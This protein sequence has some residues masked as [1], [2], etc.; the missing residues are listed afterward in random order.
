MKDDNGVEMHRAQ[1]QKEAI[2][3]SNIVGLPEE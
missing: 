2:C 3:G 1:L